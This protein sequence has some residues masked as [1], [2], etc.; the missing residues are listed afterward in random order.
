[1]V[2]GSECDGLLAHTH[3][4][5]RRGGQQFGYA[6]KRVQLGAATFLRFGNGRAS[7][8]FDR[9]KAQVTGTGMGDDAEQRR[10]DQKKG[11]DDL[12]HPFITS[13]DYG[14]IDDVAATSRPEK[15]RSCRR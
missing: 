6:M 11:E 9:L 15:R 14:L 2:R 3:C 4:Y 13:E 8:P 12:H 5:E 7:P 10:E 1:M